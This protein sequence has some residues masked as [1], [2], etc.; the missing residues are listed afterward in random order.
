MNVITIESATF[1]KLLESIE[2]IKGELNNLKDRSPL[3][4]VW[5]DNQK[6]CELLFISKR[7]LQNYRDTSKLK[8]S[9]KGHK[10]YYKASDIDTFLNSNYNLPKKK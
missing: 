4:E 2:E 9:Q 10:I 7:T 8:F 1:Q 5:M 3:K 6:V